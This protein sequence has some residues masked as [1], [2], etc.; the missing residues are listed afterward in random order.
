MRREDNPHLTE[1][2]LL[3]GRVADLGVFDG[4]EEDWWEVFFF[5]QPGVQDRG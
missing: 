1:N 4:H 2:G 3:T 5:L